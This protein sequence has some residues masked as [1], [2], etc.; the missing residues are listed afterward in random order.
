MPSECSTK[1]TLDMLLENLVSD[2]KELEQEGM[3]ADWA[4]QNSQ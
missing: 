2:L 3:R 4:N 1:R